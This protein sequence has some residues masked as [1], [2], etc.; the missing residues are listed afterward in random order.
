VF[1]P[2]QT[3]FSQHHRNS[4]GFGSGLSVGCLKVKLTNCWQE[5]TFFLSSFCV[6]SFR[7]LSCCQLNCSSFLCT[8]K[9]QAFRSGTFL[10][11]DS[12]PKGFYSG[13]LDFAGRQDRLRCESINLNEDVWE[14]GCFEKV[15]FLRGSCHL[16]LRRKIQVD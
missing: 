7:K 3:N 8:V 11:A 2:L 14:I 5:L 10:Q 9:R 1:F 16:L 12:E 4:F 13:G 15:T 6:L